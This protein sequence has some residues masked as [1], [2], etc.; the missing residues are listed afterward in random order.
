MS[1][2]T[3]Q[4]KKKQNEAL[5]FIQEIIY[6]KNIDEVEKL[7]IE[8]GR[9]FSYFFCSIN[10]ETNVNQQIKSSAENFNLEPGTYKVFAVPLKSLNSI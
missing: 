6:C 8:I 2:I 1:K 7:K 5:I 10:D 4:K 3:R 9:N